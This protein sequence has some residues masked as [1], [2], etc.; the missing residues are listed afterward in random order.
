ME[1]SVIRGAAHLPVYTKAAEK[2]EK[3]ELN[4]EGNKGASFQKGAKR[5]QSGS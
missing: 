3:K 5:S 1:A 2:N 4:A